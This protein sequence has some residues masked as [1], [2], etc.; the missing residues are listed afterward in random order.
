MEEKIANLVTRNFKL[1]KE[2]LLLGE[3]PKT[4]NQTPFN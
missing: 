2:E 1:K 3:E 4:S